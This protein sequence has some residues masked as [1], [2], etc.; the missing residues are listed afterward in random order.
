LLFAAR[1]AMAFQFQSIAALGPVL[2]S[3]FAMD[4][5]L[6]G[7]L[8]GLYLLPGVVF[9]LPGGLLGQRFGDKRIAVFGLALMAIGG[10]WVGASGSFASAAAGR[11]LSGVGGVLLNIHLTKMTTDWFAGREIV[12]AMA[13]L[14]S[15]WPIG[16]GIALVLLPP[17]ATATTGST[18]LATTALASALPLIVMLAAYRAP[19]DLAASPASWRFRLSRTEWTLSLLSGTVWGLYNVAFILVLTFGPAFLTA[20]AYS[21]ER[22]GATVSLVSWTILVSLPLGGVVAERLKRDD[23]TMVGCFVALAGAIF[24]VPTTIAPA[25]MF[26]AIGLLSG[27]PASLIMK[28]PSEALKPENRAAGM[29][30]FFTCYYA[31]MAGLVPVAGLLRD[32]S[33]SPSAPLYLAAAMLLGATLSLAGFRAV[34]R[35]S[36]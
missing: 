24:V 35:H 15:S 36:A 23:A 30:V 12:L 28:L 5:T 17:I 27:P 33:D 14:L 22:A 34:Q 19:A 7:T 21:V 26:A 16:I 32:A 29:G 25:I 9:S 2:I 18:A 1:T 13:L 4:Y 8:V 10:G 6:L 3:D 20:Q 31:G 11:L